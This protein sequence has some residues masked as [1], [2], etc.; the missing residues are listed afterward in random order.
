MA[1]GFALEFFEASDGTAEDVLAWA[2]DKYHPRIAIACSFQ[3][4]VLI[5][6]ARKIRPD[7]PRA[8][9]RSTR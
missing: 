7:P 4:A 6:M 9:S 1:V 8:I 3:H 2:L 5:D